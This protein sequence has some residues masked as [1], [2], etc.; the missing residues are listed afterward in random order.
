VTKQPLIAT[1]HR[2]VGSGKS[3]LAMDE[4]MPTCDR[5]FAGEGIPQTEAARRGRGHRR[6][7]EMSAQ[8]RPCRRS[9]YFVSIRRSMAG[10][11]SAWLNATNVSARSPVSTLRWPAFSFARASQQPSLAI[12]RGLKARVA[13]AQDALTHRARCIRAALGGEYAAAMER[14]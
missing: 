6:N 9:V 3:L 7:G 11:A 13:E 14:I 12:W 5:R 1:A 4:S 2:L 8:G 10:S